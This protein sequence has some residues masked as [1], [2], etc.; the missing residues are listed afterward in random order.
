[1]LTVA[2]CGP[3]ATVE[4][5]VR[6]SG[7]MGCWGMRLAARH[8]RAALA[9]GWMTCRCGE[10]RQFVPGEV[11]GNPSAACGVD[12]MMVTLEGAPMRRLVILLVAVST[13]MLIA[14]VAWA[15]GASM[16]SIDGPGTGGGGPIDVGD[17]SGGGDPEPGSDLERLAINTGIY[18]VAFGEHN[19]RL[20]DERPNGELGSRHTI[21]WTVPQPDGSNATVV[22]DLYPY[23]DRGAVTYTRAGQM[24][25]EG[26]ETREGWF[27]GGADLTAVLT[28]VGLAADAPPL[29]R[30]AVVPVVMVTGGVL[31]LLALVLGAH[32][33]A[34]A[35]RR[36]VDALAGS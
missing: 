12:H 11:G 2:E 26:M 22:Q 1:M 27:L 7:T 31:A 13:C 15:K 24:F 16:A 14:P 6:R 18:A 17:D 35:R 5:T 20:A 29:W 23:A 8:G 30:P 19:S 9:S 10:R 32:R 36:P 25:F 3:T 34:A 4:W 33:V 21:T 28:E